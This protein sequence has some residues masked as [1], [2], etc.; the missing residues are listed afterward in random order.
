TPPKQGWKLRVLSGTSLGKE[1][2]LPVGRYVLGSKAPAGIIIPDPSISPQHVEIDVR[3][4]C[5]VVTDCSRGAGMTVNGKRVPSAQLAPSDH[6]QVGNFRFEFTNPNYVPPAPA[7]KAGSVRQRL[8]QLPLYG[9]VGLITF[10]V[11]ALL[12]ILLAT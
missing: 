2:D 12:Y 4:D 10:A 9:R 7:A 5:V 11:A 1:F 3:T 8:M 6:V